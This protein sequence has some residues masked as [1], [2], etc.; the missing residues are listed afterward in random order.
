MREYLKMNEDMS[1]ILVT[2]VDKIGNCTQLQPEDVIMEID[3]N[4][5]GNDG[6]VNAKS[7]GL[8]DD[9][10]RIY[11]THLISRKCIGDTVSLKIF[12]QGKILTLPIKAQPRQYVVGVSDYINKIQYF[13]HAGFVFI[14]A[15]R[16]MLLSNEFN[17]R[18][19]TKKIYS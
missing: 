11:F 13:I 1:G 5:I 7:I 9:S 15:T 2:K 8:G 18:Y 19:L 14:S 12:R 16:Q 6:N 4:K 17:H 10:L 3:D